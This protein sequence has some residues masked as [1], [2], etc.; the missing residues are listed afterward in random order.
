MSYSPLSLCSDCLEVML[1]RPLDALFQGDLG[2]CLRD[3]SA[4]VSHTFLLL[5]GPE[6][7]FSSCF[8]FKKIVDDG[9]FLLTELSQGFGKL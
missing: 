9:L 7:S 6:D 3:V 4:L 8:S 1:L 5:N 2:L